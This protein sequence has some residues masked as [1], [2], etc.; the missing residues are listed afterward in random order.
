ML[1]NLDL[2]LHKREVGRGGWSLRNSYYNF[3]HFSLRLNECVKT[4]V[5]EGLSQNLLQYSKL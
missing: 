4:F 3:K 2:I 1:R 5:Q